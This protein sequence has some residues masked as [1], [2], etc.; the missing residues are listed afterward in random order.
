MAHSSSVRALSCLCLLGASLGCGR[1]GFEPGGATTDGGATAGDG[2]GDGASPR[3]NLGFITAG[4]YDGALGGVAGADAVCDAEAAAAGRPGT[5]IAL[6]WSSER[7][8]PGVLL[9]GSA[10][11]VR[12]DGTWLADTAAE[13]IVGEFASPLALTAD[14]TDVLGVD[15]GGPPNRLWNGLVEG[16]CGDW[17]STVGLGDQMWLPQWGRLSDG[18]WDCAESLR[19]A[20]FEI[21]HTATRPPLPITARRVFVT[22]ADLSLGGGVA[23]ADALCNAEAAAQ[24]LGTSSAVIGTSTSAAVDRL[25]GGRTTRYQRIDGL[26]VGLLTDRRTWINLDAA[27][28]HQV[29]SAWT[30][31]S[32]DAISTSTCGDWASTVGTSPIGVSWDYSG[33]FNSSATLP[34]AGAAR[35][36][37]A[38]R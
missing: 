38:E 35:V 29:A 27:G 30:G 1:L 36:Y 19:L 32:I 15:S 13:I 18:M 10:G 4:A 5:Y 2:G 8:D 11:W 21:G 25:P 33:S 16:T 23:A 20:C 14:G 28:A 22:S 6:L 34:C 9:A 3:A 37:C 12:A 17:R 26:E 7:P 24:G 31:G